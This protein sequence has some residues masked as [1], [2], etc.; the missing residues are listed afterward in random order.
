VKTQCINGD[1]WKISSPQW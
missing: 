1:C